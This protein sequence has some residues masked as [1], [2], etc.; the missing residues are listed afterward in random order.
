MIAASCATLPRRHR[1]CCRCRRRRHRR[2]RCRRR[3]RRRR[4]VHP[5]LVTFGILVTVGPSNLVIKFF[6]VD[7]RSQKIKLNFPQ[8]TSPTTTRTKT[9]KVSKK[10]ISK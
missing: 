4:Y 10:M 8:A 9:L 5:L 1:G 7:Q 6:L 2:C 3:R